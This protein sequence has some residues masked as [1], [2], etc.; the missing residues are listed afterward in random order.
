MDSEKLE[1]A[2]RLIIEGIGEN[3]NREGLIET[4]KRFAKMLL[5]QCEYSEITNDEIAE[6]TI[7]AFN[8]RMITWLS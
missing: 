1:K 3:P 6:K 7:N 8:V 5:E 4:P 2:A